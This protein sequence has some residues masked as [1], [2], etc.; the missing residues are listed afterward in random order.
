M[1]AGH[2]ER[3]HAILSASGAHRW[4]KC[5]KSASL[6]KG[7]ADK[8]SDFAEEGTFA[9]ELSELH[10]AQMYQGMTKRTFNSRLKKMKENQYY[11]E[12]LHEYVEEYVRLVEERIN[13][14]KARDAKP[15]LMFEER[16]DLSEYVPASFGTGDVIIYSGGVLEII[17][18]KFGKGIEVSAE[19]NAQL[20]LYALGALSLF[21][22][23]EDV[24]EVTT[25]IIQPRLD[26]YSMESLTADELKTWGTEYVKPRAEM[27]WNGEGEF[28]PGEHCRFCKVKHTCRARA[29]AY[30]NVP[31]KLEDPNL[32]TAEEIAEI[33]FQA[34]EIQKW[35][36]D[37]Q[38]YALEQA[39]EGTAYDGFKLVEGR[40]NR[41]YT[42]EQAVIERLSKNYKEDAYLERKLLAITK[43]E[44]AIGKKQFQNLLAEYVVKPQGK[45]TLVPESDKRPALG[46]DTAQSEFDEI[47]N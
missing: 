15:S 7:I 4:L 5:T 27:A 39:M 38:D 16:L 13:E 12:E 22:L 2:A 3:S 1:T 25:T 46:A 42:D 33:L 20:R 19:N 29:E 26:N 31:K 43:L 37:V 21:E 6:E 8:T 17:D 18:L 44:K 41:K 35:A 45:P 14:A 9:H 47:K 11:T 32:L 24:E 34:D 36:K 40:S 23:I 30:L 28:V 10:F